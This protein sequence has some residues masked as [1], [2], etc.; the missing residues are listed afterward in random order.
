MNPK[1]QVVYMLNKI[2]PGFD[3]YFQ[4]EKDLWTDEEGIITMCGIFL[5]LA[6]YV[7]SNWDSIVEENRNELFDYLEMKFFDDGRTDAGNSVAVCFIETISGN[8]EI[9]KYL[10][11]KCE[12]FNVN[13]VFGA[14]YGKK[15]IDRI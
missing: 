15:K 1:K 11:P 2:L 3:S 4:V 14:S 8:P 5:V 6:E 7:E 12:D 10:R 13:N 9:E